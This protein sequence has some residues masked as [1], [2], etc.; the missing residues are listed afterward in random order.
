MPAAAQGKAGPG[1]PGS[2]GKRKTGLYMICVVRH[3]DEALLAS[4]KTAKDLDPGDVLEIISD[5]G[6]KLVEGK[7]FSEPADEGQTVHFT[8]DRKG[9]VFAIMT[10]SSYPQR[11]AF[12][13]LEEVKERWGAEFGSMVK[14]AKT[15]SLTADSKPLL[16]SFVDKY[17]DPAEAGDALARVQSKLDQATDT[18]REN[19]HI[20]L[21][22]TEQLENIEEQ[23]EALEKKSAEFQRNATALKNKMWWK[24]CK[25][26]LIIAAII[27]VIL[28]III[29][30]VVVTAQAGSSAKNAAQAL[31]GPP[32][33]APAPG[34]VSLLPTPAPSKPSP[35][36]T[37]APH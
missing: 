32:A 12:S 8:L 22:N 14:A 21:K 10:K 7:R 31:Q 30:P 24:A 5:K 6:A 20:A 36:P 17:A 3:S 23:S 29:V 4:F 2:G 19:I 9:R 28:I 37:K 18:M 13:V 27:V 16:K 33:P 35:R 26:K 11:V 25:T 1:G 34:P 15:N